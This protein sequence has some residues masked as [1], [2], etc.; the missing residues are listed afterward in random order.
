[1]NV[2][3]VGDSDGEPAE[4]AVKTAKLTHRNEAT[5]H[6]HRSLP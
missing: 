1:M 4:L 6:P 5:N 3:P 2:R